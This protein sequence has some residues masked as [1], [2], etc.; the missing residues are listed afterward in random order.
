MEK[1]KVPNAE[2]EKE[3]FFLDLTMMA[4][5][6]EWSVSKSVRH[7]HDDCCIPLISFPLP[8]AAL[9]RKSAICFHNLEGFPR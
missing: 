7:A 5:A 6:S 4:M 2:R 8:A 9:V 1:E 3:S